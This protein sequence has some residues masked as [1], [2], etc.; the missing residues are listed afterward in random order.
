[1]RA[2]IQ[3]VTSANVTVSGEQ[4]AAI[5]RG[6]LVLLGVQS[7]DQDAQAH[8]LADK[9]AGMRIFAD[10]QNKM[11]LSLLDIGGAALIVSQFT[12]LADTRKGRR[13]SFIAAAPPSEGERLYELFCDSVARLGVRVATG[14]FGADMQV[15]LV[16]D[17]P[18]TIILDTRTS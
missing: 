10:E 12:L 14:R 13:P 5:D 9:I 1:M 18:V 4:I 15:R 2:V 6:L 17:G 7:G 11:N 3:R 8:Y 16:N